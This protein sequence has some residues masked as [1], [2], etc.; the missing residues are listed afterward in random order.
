MSSTLILTCVI[1]YSALLFFVVWLTSRKADNESYFI[2]NRSSGWYVVAYGMIGASLSGVTFMSVPGWVG[3]TQFSYMM[4]VFGYLVGYAVIAAVLLPVYYKMNLTS[5]YSYLE[6]RFGFWS[7]KTGAFY[8]LLSRTIG[9]SFRLFIVVNVLQTFVFDAWGVPFIVTVATFIL[10]ILLYTYKGGVKT[11]VWTDTLQTT[12]MLLAVVFSII[13]ISRQ[14]HLGVHGLF[15]TVFHGGYSK[16]IQTDWRE[17]NYFLKHFFGGMFIAIAMT[18]LDQEMM[19]KNISVKTLPSSQKNMITFS[20]VLVVV[21]LMFLALGALLYT[22]I[23]QKG[24]AFHGRTTD[25]LFPTVA[26]NYLG[27]FSAVF[28]SIGLISAAYP[29]A[30]GALTALTSSFCIDFLGLKKQNWSEERKKNVR[31][32]VHISFAAL[33]LMVIVVFRIIN[34]EAVI[35]KLFTVASYTYGPLLGL[36]AF[37]LINSRKV[38]DQLVPVVCILA[39]VLCYFLNQQ[40]VQWF[41]G[42]KFGFEL[43]IVNGLFTYIGLLLTSK[44]A[45]PDMVGDGS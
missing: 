43:L 14:L 39:P 4:V 45:A 18:G 26:L 33:L 44:K 17:K 10:L 19:Q 13:L 1:A 2:G 5:I 27:I 22:F 20:L 16:I 6:S 15:N 7:Y 11:I 23:Q 28:F 38:N 24:I 12:F 40:S 3:A 36:Y 21:N 41:D 32:T 29:S 25:D 37:G 30:D 42:Y 35:S 9:A 8:F 34:D 31:Y